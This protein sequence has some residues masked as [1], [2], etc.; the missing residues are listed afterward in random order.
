MAAFPPT[1]KIGFPKAENPASAILRTEMERGIAK[2]RRM[3]ADVMVKQEVTAFFDTAQQATEWESWFY[4][5]IGA[6]ADFFDWRDQRTGTTRQ[7]RIVDGKPGALTPA[8]VN[9][10]Y[11]QRTFTIEWVRSAV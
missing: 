5:S 4:G 7:V 3:S 8:T 9:W 2:Q 6:G 1:V 10:A 11:S